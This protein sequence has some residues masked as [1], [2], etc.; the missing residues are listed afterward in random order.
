MK[1]YVLVKGGLGNQM[2]QYAFYL[3]MK[4]KGASCVLDTS[5]FDVVTMHQG[6]ELERVFGI[7]DPTAS[8][9]WIHRNTVRILYKY[10]PKSLVFA[11]KPFV[12]CQ[13][14]L[15]SK[16]KYYTGCWIHPLYFMSIEEEVRGAF[17]FVGIS[18]KNKEFADELSNIESV[19][20][21]IRRGDY[22]NSPIYDVCKEDYHKNA[23]ARILEG[24]DNP[25]FI[26]FSDD[27]QWCNDYMRR[28]N[29]NYRMVDWNNGKDSYQDMYLMSKCKHNIIANSTFS[30]WGAWLNANPDKIVVSPSKWT[31]E[32]EMNYSIKNW[33]FI[34]V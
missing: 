20:L 19:S 13:D 21:H 23:I 27:V 7:T 11:D 6:F 34:N 15:E 14:A 12:Y 24:V 22:L 8:R 29:V 10:K 1:Q 18:E 5:L 9:S 30:W 32:S 16:R 31:T 2:F 3:S 4:S 25:Q 33:K 28:F 17:S 26:V